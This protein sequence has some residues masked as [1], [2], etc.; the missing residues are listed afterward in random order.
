MGDDE[1]LE[2][3][4]KIG[5]L[6]GQLQRAYEGLAEAIRGY[7]NLLEVDALPRGSHW[8]AEAR[9]IIK[10]LRRAMGER[11]RRDDSAS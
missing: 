2:Y 4:Q 7:E 11:E 1:R 9:R 10:N 8:E 3:A 5:E 6:R